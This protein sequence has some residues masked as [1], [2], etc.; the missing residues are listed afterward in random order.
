[1]GKLEEPKF[2]YLRE[3]YS[4]EELISELIRLEAEL[5]AD[6]ANHDYTKNDMSQSELEGDITLISQTIEFIH[7]VLEKRGIDNKRLKE[8]KEEIIQ[9]PKERVR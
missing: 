7:L 2:Q 5:S 1:M 9:K 6:E 8:L 4:N 3:E